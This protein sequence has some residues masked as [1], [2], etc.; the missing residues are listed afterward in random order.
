MANSFQ[1]PYR[2]FNPWL[3]VASSPTRPRRT[4]SAPLTSFPF[5]SHL[6][7]ATPARP[8]LRELIRE[9]SPHQPAD[10]ISMRHEDRCLA[11]APLASLDLNQLS[12][13]N[14]AP[15]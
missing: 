14:S 1:G 13:E 5:L 12:T 8:D 7:P 10:L 6:P 4:E 9:S 3:G 15:I 2:F 11:L